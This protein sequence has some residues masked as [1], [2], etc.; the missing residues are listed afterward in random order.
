MLSFNLEST[1]VDVAISSARKKQLA[2]GEQE[3]LQNIKVIN[4]LL[5]CCRYLSREALEFRGSDDDIVGNFRQNSQPLL[6]LDS[7]YEKLD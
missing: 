4:V 2:Q 3:C 5:D 7:I 6:T 1:H